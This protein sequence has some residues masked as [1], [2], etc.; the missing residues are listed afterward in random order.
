MSYLEDQ[1]RPIYG[2]ATTRKRYEAS[3][4]CECVKDDYSTAQMKIVMSEMN[5][6]LMRNQNY[7]KK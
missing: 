1:L 7:D 3:G 4:P 5:G 6:V 2:I